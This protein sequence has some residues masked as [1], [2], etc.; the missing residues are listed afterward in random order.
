MCGI[1]VWHIE[2]LQNRAVRGIRIVLGGAHCALDVNANAALM[3]TCTYAYRS[4]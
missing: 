1:V 2:L 4:V 3:P